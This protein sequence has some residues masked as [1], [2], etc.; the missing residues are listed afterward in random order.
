MTSKTP[1]NREDT[2]AITASCIA[3]FPRVRDVLNQY[4]K[5]F[6]KNPPEGKKGAILDG[7]DIGTA[8]CPAAPVKLF[9]TAKDEIRA[10]R[11]YEELNSRGIKGYICGCTE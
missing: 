1:K 7:R 10:K 11:R 2:V 5:D 4:Q 3:A 8:I 9:L 6:A